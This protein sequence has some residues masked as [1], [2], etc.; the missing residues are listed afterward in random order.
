MLSFIYFIIFVRKRIKLLQLLSLKKKVIKI[1]IKD[2][3]QKLTISS[4]STAAERLI[5]K[6]M[7]RILYYALLVIY[8]LFLLK[9]FKCLSNIVKY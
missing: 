4:I 9:M 6:S 5:N 3:N 1:A 7:D 2:I 8:F